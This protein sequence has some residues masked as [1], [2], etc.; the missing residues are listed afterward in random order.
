MT[1]LKG[2]LVTFTLYIFHFLTLS[3]LMRVKN[4]PHSRIQVFQ[5]KYFCCSNI[6]YACSFRLFYSETIH[7]QTTEG[8][9]ISI[10]PGLEESG[11]TVRILYA[12]CSV[13]ELR[14][15]QDDKSHCRFKIFLSH[16]ISFSPPN[17]VSTHKH[18]PP[19]PVA[20]RKT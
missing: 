3:L 11:Y 18:F 6:L 15:G 17:G 13:A 5:E 8:R 4:I 7:I 1:I 9:H 12:V 16:W 14:P 10:L 20:I 19:H 2:K